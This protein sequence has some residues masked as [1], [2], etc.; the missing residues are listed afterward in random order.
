MTLFVHNNAGHFTT[1]ETSTFQLPSRYP[2]GPAAIKDIDPESNTNE[3]VDYHFTANSLCA[4]WTGFSHHENVQ[5]EVGVGDT[6]VVDNVITF[7]KINSTQSHCLSHPK[8]ASGIKYF[9]LLRAT[10]SGGSTIS[11]SNG[12]E[13]VSITE[14][15]NALRVYVGERC[16][17]NPIMIDSSF[18][19]SD[20]VNVTL[21]KHAGLEVAMTYKLTIDGIPLTEIHISTHHGSIDFQL[22]HE[23]KDNDLLITPYTDRPIIEIKTAKMLTR[24]VVVHIRLVKCPR[25][26]YQQSSNSVS[27]FWFYDSNKHL[28]FEV[29]VMRSTCSNIY[30]QSCNDFLTTF[31]ASDQANSHRFDRGVFI[32]GNWYRIAVR[33]CTNVRCLGCALSEP[34]LFGSKSPYVNLK[35]AVLTAREHK[36]CHDLSIVW[37]YFTSD[38]DVILY[39]WTIAETK[40]GDQTII[41]W[42]FIVPN[43][44]NTIEVSVYIVHV[45]I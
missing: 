27:A 25:S 4:K 20:V 12:V 17:E 13:I 45:K 36:A 10:C 11:S 34:F 38:G 39:R 8:L 9:V 22:S 5:L 43:V 18:N 15:L 2:P 41:N 14:Y 31:V 16:D 1:V 23:Y 35:D 26:M 7:S 37:N 24:P 33:P 30:N 32:S 29:S 28:R 3:D 40:F 44:T 6:S 21:G 19:L 42:R